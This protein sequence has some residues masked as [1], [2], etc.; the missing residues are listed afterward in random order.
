[1]MPMLTVQAPGSVDGAPRSESYDSLPFAP[2]PVVLQ[3]QQQRQ[4]QPRQG[5]QGPWESR[6][7]GVCTFSPCMHNFRSA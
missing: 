5:L 6:E 7:V 4:W 1:M 2:S 3:Q